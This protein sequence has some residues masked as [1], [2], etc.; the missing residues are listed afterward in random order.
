MKATTTRFCV[1]IAAAFLLIST[2]NADSF[3]MKYRQLFVKKN[4]SD[5]EGF[6]T[7]HSKAENADIDNQDTHI[8]RDT[9]PVQARENKM[10]MQFKSSS[11]ASNPHA[12]WNKQHRKNNETAFAGEDIDKT[13]SA[14]SGKSFDYSSDNSTVQ[15][16]RNRNLAYDNHH[17][18]WS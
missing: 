2:A 10:F 3:I 16:T 14:S 1:V 6:E 18:S 7:S 15:N 5:P 4:N 12:K 11:G 17:R 13:H 9:A 8:G